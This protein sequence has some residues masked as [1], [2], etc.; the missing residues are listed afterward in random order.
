MIKSTAEAAATE[1]FGQDGNDSLSLG[2][3]VDWADGG[4][5]N[6]SLFGG[7]GATPC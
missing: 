5:G 2:N 1:F 3:G 4:E 6:D 7:V